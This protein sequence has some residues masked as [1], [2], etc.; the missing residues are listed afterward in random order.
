MP[1]TVVIVEDEQAQRQALAQAV[2]DAP[3]LSLLA[4]AADLPEALRLMRSA[5]PD[6]LLVDLNLPSGSGLDLIRWTK[7]NQPACEV[8]VIT[9]SG[10][11][12]QVVASLE[13]GATGY[14]LKGS[15]SAD[16]A[17]HIRVLCEGGSPISPTIARRLLTRFT[18]STTLPSL[19]PA[20]APA[21]APAPDSLSE[22]SAQERSVLSLCAK[23]YTYQEIANL[24]TLSSHT[25]KTYV[26]R[27]YRKLQVHSKTEAVYEARKLNW[28]DD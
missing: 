22:L 3:D 14:L 1:H 21:P 12:R 23:G 16:I 7:S 5:P 15:S 27:I 11:E 26:K 25:V 6:V 28:L 10:D 17:G 18:P 19:P 24:L 13:A 20:P 2:S 8:M 9:W 4:C